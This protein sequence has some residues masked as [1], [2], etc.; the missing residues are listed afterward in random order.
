MSTRELRN[1]TPPIAAN[2]EEPR[3]WKAVGGNRTHLCTFGGGG[4]T[5]AVVGC[6]DDGAPVLWQVAICGPCL[7]DTVMAR[8]AAVE[9]SAHR[10]RRGGRDRQAAQ[11]GPME[12]TQLP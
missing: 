9:T 7:T 6:P 4:P 8:F 3:Q 5:E 12:Q 10:G 1:L 11:S 2:P